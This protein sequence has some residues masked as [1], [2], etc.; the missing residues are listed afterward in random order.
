MEDKKTMSSDNV[1]KEKH[2]SIRSIFMH[3]DGVDMWFMVAGFIGAVADGSAAPLMLYLVGR[4]FNKVGGA[5]STSSLDFLTHNV[6]KVALYMILIACGGCAGCFLKGY[7]WTRTSERQASRM[8]TRYLKAVLR[9]DVGYFDLNETSTAEVVTTVSNDTLIIQDVISEKVPNLIATGALFVGSYVV[10]FLILWRL[11][12]VIF[13]FII[14]LVVPSLIY[15]RILLSLARKIRVEYNKAGTVAEQAIS[16]IRTV[17]AFVGENKTA[18]EFSA[19]LQGSLKLGLRQGLAKGLAI[20]SNGIDFAVWAFIIYYGSRLVMYHGAKGGSIFTV[21]TCVAMGGQELGNGLS[22]LKPLFEACAAAERINEMI[23]RVPKIDLENLVGETLDNFLGE[24]EFKQ[25]EFAYPSRP[26]S[27]I[28]K[29][30]CLKI[31][32]GKTLALV[33]S[34]GSGK[35][36]VISLLQRFYDPLGGDI[37]LDGVSIKKFQ[38]KWLRS[39]MGL[40]SQEPTLFATS[41][42]ENILFGNEE[43]GMEEVIEAAKASNAHN[44]ISQL[45]L[46][47]DT[48]V[49]ERGVQMSGGQKQRIAIARAMIKAPKILLLDEATSALDSESERIVQDA[50]DKAS[51]GRTM[52]IVA[53]RLSTIRH[54]DL[55]AVVQNGQVIEIGSHNELMVNKNGFYPMLVQLQPTEQVKVECNKKSSVNGSAHITNLEINIASSHRVSVASRTSSANFA[56]SNLVSLDGEVKVE[57]KKL[58]TPSFKRLLALNLPEWKQATIGCLSAIL[59]GAMQPLSAFTQGSVVSMFFLED[60]GEIKEKAKAYAM[61]FLGFSLFSLISNI[62]LHYN[63]TYMGEHLTKRIRE[64]LLSKI[65]TFEV[66]WFD[67]DENSSGPV[68]ARLEKDA[69]VVRSLIGDGV[70]FLVQTISGVTLACALGLFIAWRL[71]I[72]M[73]VV[74]PLI[75]LAIYARIA[76]LKRMSRKA[77]EAQQESSKLATE[78]VSNHQT[79]TAFS[80]QD[81]ILKMLQKSQ[82]SPRKENVRQSWLAGLGLG[83]SRFLVSG[84][85]AF[86][87]WYGGKLVSEG[88]ITSKALIET[89]LILIN[90]GFFIAK[91][92]SMTSDWAKSVEVVGSLFDILDRY[93]RIE[94]DDSNGYVAKEITG[95]VEICDI[96]FAYPA[97]PNMIILKDFS[98]SIEAGKSTALVGQSGSGKST[99]ISLIERFYDPLKGAVKIDGRDIRLYNLRSLRKQIALVSQEPA[100]FSGTV[101]E[102]ILYGASDKTNESEIIEAA[103][104]ANAHD[105]IAG[106]ADGYDTWCGDRG[107]QLSGGQKQ[108]IAIARAILRN[109]TMLLLDEA[110]SALDGKSE[111]VVQE[112]LERVM[113]GRTSVVVAHRLSTIQN[114]DVIVV[115]EKGKV[116]EKGNHSSLLAKGPTGAYCSLICYRG[117]MKRIRDDI[118]AGSQFKRPSGSSRDESYGQNQVLGGGGDGGGG[119]RGGGGSGSG[120]MGGMG[121]GGGGTPQKLTTNDALTYLKEV[122][123]MFQ[124]QKEK[125]DMFLE[126]MKDFKAQRTDTVG[127]IA[128]VKE[129]FQG[130]NNLIY[131]FNTFLPKGYEI[132]L[133]EEE[134]LPKKTVEFDEAISFV[135]KIKKRF[136]KDE[137]VYKSFLDILNMYRKEHKDINEVYSEVAS[138][139]EDHQDLL[140]EFTRF[141]P[142]SSA[143]PLTQQVPY[144]RNSTQR[145]IERSS[146]TPNVRHTQ[147]DKQRRRDRI[148]SHADRDLSVDCQDLD[149]DKAIVKMQKEHRKRVEKENRDRRT[150]DHDDL[151]HEN[152]D[153][154]MQRFPDKKRSGRKIEGF[155]SYD[156][157]DTLKSMCDQ[158]FIFCEKVKERLC[159]SDDYQAF[160][161][162]LN[163][164]S[165]G[166]IK[167]NDLQNLVTDLLGKHPDLMIEF[168][169]FLERCEN[170]D[171][172]LAGVISKKSLSGDAHASRPFK[173]EEKD[174]EHKREPEEAKEKEK[175]RG[176]YMEKSI[177]ELDLS[178]CQRCT[179]SYRLL[180]DDYPIPSASQRSELG[181]QVL[182]D[183]WVSVTSGSEDYSFTH[184]RR[185]QYEESLFRCEDDRFELDMLLESVSSTAKRVE[186]LL[187]SINENK[188]N[189]VSPFRAEEHLTV[190]NLRCIERLYGDHGLD[191]L[192]I[193]RKTPAL[194]L[195]VILTRLKQK[196]EEWTKCRSDFNKVWAEIYSKNHY[197]SLDHRSFYFK[198]QDSKNLSAKSLVAEIKELKEK[199]QKEDDV[200]VASVA[201]HRQPLAPHLKYEY[202]DVDIYEDLY[203]LIE[204]SSEEICSTKEQLNKVMRLWT[205]F[206]EPMLG[207]SP[208]PNGSAATIDAG[209]ALNPAVNCTTSSI[210]ESDGNPGAVAAVSSRQQKAAS[211]GDGNSSPELT[212]SCRNG[213]TNVETLPKEEHS[214]RICRDDSKLE[215]EIKFIAD[216]R[217][218]I[219]KLKTGLGALAIE[220]ENKHIGSSVEG[221]SACRPCVSASE[222]HEPEANAGLVH[223]LEGGDVT[224]HVLLANGVPTDGSNASRYHDESV[225][226]SKIEKEEG[227]LSPNGDFEEDNFVAYVDTG[228]KAVP[229]ANHG[230]ETRQYRSVNG[231]EL[232][233]KDA[234]GENDADDEDSENASE[235]GN[236]ASGSESAGDECSHEEEEE[237]EHD[238]VDGKA[239]SEGEA[240]GIADTHVGGNRASLSVSERC[241]FT[242]KPLAKHVPPLLPEEAGNSCVF[243]ANDDFYVLFRLHQI[244]YER[245][246][247]AKTNSMD[248]EMKWKNSEGTSPDLYARFMSALYSL[249]DGSAD[250]AK[251]EDEC[252]AIIG[253]QSYVLFTLDKLL[254]KLVKQLQA[255]SADDMDN[256]LLQ[257]FEYEK[258][259][260]HRKTMDSVYYE[261]A[262]V[263]L[264]E[265]NIYRLKCSSSPSRLS[266]QLMDNVIEKP[267]AFA[268]SMEPNFSAFLQNDFLSV[269]PSKKEPHGITLRRNKKKYATLDEFAAICMAM[270]GVELVNGLEN[271][272]AC[273]SYKI[274]YV[275]DTEDFFFRRRR[276]SPQRKSQYNNQ[277]GVQRFHRFL[278]ASQ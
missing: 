266:I 217:P 275:L 239:E 59:F 175:S 15:G 135:N 140:E 228:L 9:Q 237:V 128:R 51:I 213:L 201:G 238:E 4:M 114:C 88:Q 86:D 3:A 66:G 249:L 225:S 100:L 90:T 58:S 31:P 218:G 40:V 186:D 94:P 246:S 255:V 20:G 276:N 193:L 198:Q 148:T 215:E 271:K 150:R 127:V 60:H 190:L 56:A 47:Y 54:A 75:I 76:L 19:A 176:E 203:K 48:Q 254:Y 247:F 219:N 173:L 132:T 154:N 99:V 39:Q 153:F 227:E 84:I 269:F 209:K 149:A 124:D 25:V 29:N 42:K 216:K 152:K 194:A 10:A 67:Q 81:R 211:H 35:S 144:G 159:S 242:V 272:I 74:Q 110:T 13:P 195:P 46:G 235:A 136:Q 141:L 123:E 163:I 262:R 233:Y 139:F 130:H 223:S 104:A 70:S 181:A 83:L 24:F 120:A 171:G 2:E 170:T 69:S 185:N 50:L 97:R 151:E 96:D 274:S 253:N 182:N 267:E 111:K 109:P 73:M 179:P 16:S 220:A 231:K 251:F 78:A 77:I 55:I 164:Y 92:A 207:V 129:L 210:A 57:D 263:L 244:L 112:A 133:D 121:A 157:K 5:G 119:E 87:F 204:Y 205:T 264:H 105:F 250:N 142:D 131:G 43:A 158:G 6:N 232:N 156:D 196:Q 177:Q 102:N 11:A 95:H 38:L 200:L 98:I 107:V 8:R 199:N 63:F 189:M 18:T 49:G 85:I 32:A 160:L 214:G 167:R 122:K 134:S 180:P 21:G 256:K 188:I 229:K 117:K 162:C 118:Y 62:I 22:D 230:G 240:E 172:L 241:L 169:Q 224:K 23:T 12:L 143:A 146:A 61:V 145:Y 72:V 137:H 91:A 71:A 53:H 28:F 178:N 268:V 1:K 212:N 79:I 222:E 168:N 258:S 80:S 234:G 277:A 17:Y 184:M 243:Y 221:V 183:H 226:P 101:K 192:E 138:L 161:K 126:V 278:S 93:T 206:L 248:S 236:C 265:E 147:I 34:S 115:L 7:C 26:K 27:I 36:T 125:Y 52:V 82:E 252:R 208:R 41:I 197:K 30:F 108:R 166:I 37:L 261:N 174:R 257:L 44:F 64:R 106:L 113:V 245:I 270:E 155:A 103:K 187:N 89:Y 273:N 202:L 14:L 116:I 65:L 260:K 259:R 191:V 68:C 33:G 45:S 165:N